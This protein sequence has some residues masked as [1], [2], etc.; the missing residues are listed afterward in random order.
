MSV[1]RRPGPARH[2]D[3]MA[4]GGRLK[5]EELRMDSMPMELM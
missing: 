3:Q 5:T 1:R 4:E 2:C